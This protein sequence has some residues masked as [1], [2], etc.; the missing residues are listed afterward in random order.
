[1]IK[2]GDLVTHHAVA[3]PLHV[4]SIDGCNAWCLGPSTNGLP[5]PALFNFSIDEL[6]QMPSPVAKKKGPYDDFEEA[7][8]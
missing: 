1:M 6:K 5:F 3:Q 2:S 7:P 4:L 8:F